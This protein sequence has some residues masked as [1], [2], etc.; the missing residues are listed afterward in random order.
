[1]MVLCGSQNDSLN[2]QNIMKRFKIIHKQYY[3]M[4]NKDTLK[5]INISGR[6]V[7]PYHEAGIRGK[8]VF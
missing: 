5:I 8:I 6:Y 1:M 2:G 3:Y 7:L 4:A